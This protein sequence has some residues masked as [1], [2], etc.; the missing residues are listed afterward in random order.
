MR[1]DRRNLLSA[2]VV[3]PTFSGGAFLKVNSGLID[4]RG[5]IAMNGFSEL[6]F[7]SSGDFRGSGVPV[8]SNS[9]TLSQ[10]DR[11]IGGL[12]SEANIRIEAAQIYPGTAS[13]FSIAVADV[14]DKGARTRIAAGSITIARGTRAPAA[15][16]SAGGTLTFDADVITHEGSVKAPLGS[17]VFNAG[18][19]L[20]LA[21]NSLTSVSADGWT[22][23]FG[24]TVN[25]LSWSYNGMVPLSAPP[26]KRIALNGL[27]VT[28]AEGAIQDISGGGNVQAVEWVPGIGG[29]KDALLADGLY[30]ILPKA[31]LDHAPQDSHI[32]ALKDLGYGA[33]R[34]IYDSVY[35]SAGSGVAAG[36]YVLLPGYYALLPGAHLVQKVA[37]T[38]YRDMPTGQTARLNDGSIVVAGKYSVSGGDIAEQR[39]SGFAVR[40]GSTVLKQ[41]EYRVSNAEFFANQARA[42]D[43][44]V[45]RL[46]GDAGRVSISA[47]RNLAFAGTLRGQAAPEGR[48]AEVDISGARLAVVAQKGE[49]QGPSGALELEA[50]TL[51]A[52]NASV[53]L[54]GVRSDVAAGTRINVVA[55]EVTVAEGADLSGPEIILVARDS[56]VVES[57]GIVRTSGVLPGTASDLLVDD[58]VS[59]GGALLRVSSGNQVEINRGT[60]VDRS[61]GVL[62]IQGA[63]DKKGVVVAAAQV[64]ASRSMSL[65]ATLRTMADGSLDVSD[66]GFVSIGAA[67]IRLGQNAPDD[68]DSLLISK[69]QLKGFELLDTIALRSYTGIDF[70]GDVDL[71]SD[72]FNR[73]TLDTGAINGHDGGKVNIRAR[74]I[75]LQ[76]STPYTAP[77]SSGTGVLNFYAQ[78]V[79]LGSGIKGLNGFA[80]AGITASTEIIGTGTD[81]RRVGGDIT[82]T[83]TGA[84]RVGGDLTLKSVRLTGALKSDQSIDAI[85]DTS[86]TG[87]KVILQRPGDLPDS[88]NPGALGAKLSIT[89]T[90]IDHSGT[91]DFASGKVAMTATDVAGGI[92]LQPGSV[93]SVAGA[94]RT[95]GD[96][97][98]HV[99]GGSVHLTSAGNLE[100]E[101]DSLV[102]VSGSAA[103]D[104]GTLLITTTNAAAT[105]KLEGAFAGAAQTGYRSGSA[106]LDLAAA[107]HL[108]ALNAG[109][110]HGGFSELRDMRVRTGNVEIA[111]SDTV[112]ARRVKLSVDQGSILVKGMIDASD[113]AGGGSIELNAMNNLTLDV[114]S[115]LLARGM[116][117][118]VGA[119]DA[120]SHGGEVSLSS[121]QGSLTFSEGATI[122]VS[123]NAQGK[124]DGG[125][126]FFSA[127]RTAGNNGVNATLAGDVDVGAGA[128]GGEA[129]QVSVEGFRVYTG[130]AS[131]SEE[132]AGAG[133]AGVEYAAFLDK[134][135]T[136][137]GGFRMTGIDA[138]LVR[139]QGGIE[140][141]SAGAM[142]HSAVWDLTSG[143]WSAGD[144]AGRLTLRAEGNLTLR[145]VLGM[146]NDDLPAGATWD[147]RLVGGADLNAADVMAVKAPVPGNDSGDVILTNA[148]TFKYTDVEK[149]EGVWTAKG[150]QVRTG[151]GNLDIA[152]GRDFLMN[153]KATATVAEDGEP[154]D[155][156]N[157]GK[158]PVVWPV[159]Y[160]TG[161]NGAPGAVVPTQNGSYPVDGGRISIYA[162]RDAKGTPTQQWINDW[163]RRT[164]NERNAGPNLEGNPA[165][166]WANR[167]TFRHN[168]GA[169]GGGDISIVAG[170]DINQL[171]AMSATSGRTYLNGAGVAQLDVQGGGDL[172]LTSGRD[173]I[174]GEYLLARGTGRME[175]SGAI[176]KSVR[177]AIY[178]MGES[179]DKARRHALFTL[180]AQSDVS[181]QNVS[182]PTILLLS[183][184]TGM[185]N[186]ARRTNFFTYA[187]DAQLSV[188]SIAGD[189]FL[190]SGAIKTGVATTHSDILPPRVDL[191]ALQ[192]GISSLRARSTVYPSRDGKFQALA[193][194]DIADMNIAVSDALPENLP[195]WRA[196]KSTP[197]QPV[198]ATGVVPGGSA[199]L[200][201]ADTDGLYDYRLYSGGSIID[202]NFNLPKKARVEAGRDIRNVSFDLQ[203]LSPDDV[204]SIRA[205]RDIRVTGLSR[206]NEAVTGYVN[207]NGPGRLLVQAARNIN[208]GEGTGIDARGN[209]TNASL[210]S[211]DS[212]HLTVI[213]GYS[214]SATFSDYDVLFAALKAAGT[215]DKRDSEKKADG[216]AAIAKIFNDANTGPGDITMFFS[217][218]KT[219][220]DSGIDLLTPGGNINAGLPTPQDGEIGVITYQ[221]GNVRS[222]LRGDFNVNQSKVMTLQGGDI[223]IYSRDGNID[224]G[225][226]ALDSRTTLPPRRTIKDGLISYQ[227]PLDASGS[228]IRTLSSD[229]D[230]PGPLGA[231]KP[232]DVYLFAP[233]GFIDAGEAGVSSAGNIFLLARVVFNAKNF[234]AKGIS[235]GVPVAVA[236]GISSAALGAS[237]VAASASKSVED[238]GKSASAGAAAPFGREQFRPS[239]IT[240]E[241][242]GIGD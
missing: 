54:G 225:R 58:Q 28:V 103:G 232:G 110:N 221:G 208:L 211:S 124:S 36:E 216:E 3:V 192:G 213:A 162:A 127:A 24:T 237:S 218:I 92:V 160:T 228:G 126:V 229:A 188:T 142:D 98:A 125:T 84:L 238:V 187:P 33:D 235:I 5:N 45:P 35:L 128:N 85:A 133:K 165:S 217:Q 99:N 179:H 168:V 222:Y 239:F 206:T 156:T 51:S 38:T 79:V 22:I 195:T 163:L 159:L 132:V 227:P 21:A 47:L 116:S 16:L 114:G 83:G 121:R 25:G 151:T 161:R 53:L 117:S 42:E 101:V 96:A 76:N 189:I 207:I 181:L 40:P 67:N 138:D 231:P 32:A 109:L 141:Q 57:G 69:A 205:G 78:Q 20:S 122:D 169:F 123:A 164:A 9:D 196:A 240:V 14:N 139:V 137:R 158:A 153:E 199:R 70:Y 49:G 191:A 65:D 223:L 233:A 131:T 61:R 12:V 145:N 177:T 186:T 148:S 200:V 68:Q 10:A 23:P 185:V 204:S 210:P 63:L 39:W 93:V 154:I 88:V 104:A 115:Q 2:P 170:N 201:T 18:S 194:K 26:A 112:V 43:L 81:A 82:G 203:N 80:S 111:V 7:V 75:T 184:L 220:G 52:L 4:M 74:N 241:L 86:G 152:A 91:I 172:T 44:A 209:L 55:S 157:L 242:L 180:Q 171:S 60:Q 77:T 219:Q 236:G 102:D 100:T 167:G 64:S 176:G 107:G 19:S 135:G 173:V 190:G 8:D 29:S 27:A 50:S 73:I 11:L 48:G 37:G 108:A 113:A 90:S 150:G 136:I 105:I 118:G 94:V 13:E 147:I 230:G 193:A 214:G 134:A 30:A 146:P 224:A 212:A 175:A 129:G 140:L 130:Y 174:G 41:S 149:K 71:G 72:T 166:W 17:I 215:S 89:G 46:P 120:Y 31:A 197:A 15:A 97:K 183:T 56:V 182:N 119:A 34:H 144:G 106:R 178:L 66:G 1:S 155:A 234:S 59:S 198:V 62:D 95:F 202:S 87:F 226:G 143:P 6:N